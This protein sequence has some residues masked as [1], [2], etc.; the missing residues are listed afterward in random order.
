VGELIAAQSPEDQLWYRGLVLSNK[1]QISVC[2]I[3]YGNTTEVGDYRALPSELASIRPVAMHCSLDLSPNTGE[4]NAKF[5]EL[6][7]NG[8]T[9]FTMTLI[10]QG[11][12]NVVKLLWNGQSVTELLTVEKV[13]LNGNSEHINN[14]E[15]VN[16]DVT[17]VITQNSEDVPNVI[18]PSLNGLSVTDE[19]LTDQKAK[20]KET[21]QCADNLIKEEG[22][23]TENA[24]TVVQKS[25]EESQVFVSF[26]NSPND[27]Y[28]QDEAATTVLE[29]LSNSLL[30]AEKFKIVL[31]PKV[32]ELSSAQSPEDQLWY[33]GLVLSNKPQ[34]SV[35]FIDYGNITEV[36][37]YRALP[38]E[39][40]SIIP[41]A[42][43]CSLD[44]SHST[45]QTNSMFMELA[46]NGITPFTVTMV[47]QGDVNVVKL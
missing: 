45:D 39:L 40:A 18:K 46:C 10:K 1:P 27:C 13:E 19:Q 42:K 22:K 7:G 23:T 9:P 30:N 20:P 8:I 6:A 26:L 47:E 38:S 24:S 33:R 14:V 25:N 4:T 3:D 12:L 43:H 21:V 34:I 35:R 31:D 17:D 16:K 2:F 15:K 36:G 11:D 5:M 29:D 41:L 28:I 44:L 32:G 37:N